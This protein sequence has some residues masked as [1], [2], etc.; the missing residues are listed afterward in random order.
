MQPTG[1]RNRRPDRSGHLSI[2]FVGFLRMQ[3][4][5]DEPRR[6]GEVHHLSIPFVGFL[7]M[8]PGIGRWVNLGGLL[9][10][11]IPFVGFL[12]MQ[13]KYGKEKLAKLKVYS[14]LNSLCGISSNATYDQRVVAF[15][16]KYTL[17]SLCGISSNAT[18]PD[19]AFFPGIGRVIQRLFPLV[20]LLQ[21]P[22]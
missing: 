14:T 18:E 12:R 3:L 9:I 4:R 1:G 7:R 19:S 21:Q 11:S 10:L 17:N 5:A 16:L 6:V 2:P 8:Q 22:L 20:P 13:Q 15:L